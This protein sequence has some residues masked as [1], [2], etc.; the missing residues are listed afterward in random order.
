MAGFNEPPPDDLSLK[1]AWANILRGMTSKDQWQQVGQ[2]AQNV[3]NVAP[4]VVESLARGS[5]AQIPGTLGDINDLII[6]HIGSAF[7]NAPKAP[8]TE[9][10]LQAVPR[11]TPD[12]QGSRQHEMVGSDLFVSRFTRGGA[13][14]L[15]RPC[16][17]C[18]SLL[19]SVGIRRVF[20]TTDLGTTE[21]MKL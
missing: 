20:Y 1:D 19:T 11:I 21:V 14:G 7:P 3:K 18:Q 6:N 4:S 16:S 12:Y 15:S 17:D 10:I 2:G 9:Q 5:L 13:I 8:T